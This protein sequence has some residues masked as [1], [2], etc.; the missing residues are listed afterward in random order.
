MFVL[1]LDTIE[2]F[3]VVNETFTPEQCKK[4]I[5]LAKSKGLVDAS[6]KDPEGNDILDNF[7]D[8]KIHWFSH[9]DETDFMY[10]RIATIIDSVNKDFFQFDLFGFDEVQF[11]EYNA[12]GGHYQYHVDR[13]YKETPRKLSLSIQLTDPSEFEGG[14]LLLMDGGEDIIKMEYGQSVVFPSWMLHKVNPVTKGTRHS[15]VVWA[16]GPK[17]R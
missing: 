14:E 9:T 7:R 2:R 16:T 5:E 1:N 8:S 13:L 12:P 15:L 4:I 6:T 3:V 17:F 11:T 10:K